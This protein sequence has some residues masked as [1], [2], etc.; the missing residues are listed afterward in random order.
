MAFCFVCL[1]QHITLRVARVEP[2]QSTLHHLA[3]VDNR[4]QAASLRHALAREDR[5]AWRHGVNLSTGPSVLLPPRR[6]DS[7]KAGD[8]RWRSR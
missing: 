8:S 3:C 2:G 7:A 4:G 1:F 6:V 5:R